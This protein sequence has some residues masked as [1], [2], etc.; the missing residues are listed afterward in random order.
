MKKIISGVFAL[1]IVIGTAGIAAAQETGRRGSHPRN[2]NERQ[3]HQQDRIGGGVRSG[4]LTNREI[5][6]LEREQYQIQRLEG[7]L[8]NSGDTFTKRE[9]ARVR[10]ELNQSSRHIYRAKHNR[11]D[12]N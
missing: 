3:D 5:L 8:R 9:R 4:E 6:R 1:G 7:R 11:R 10:G 12:R 2:I